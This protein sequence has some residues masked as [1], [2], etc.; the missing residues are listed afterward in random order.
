MA[1]QW[2]KWLPPTL[3]QLKK[4]S[5]KY[6]S[7]DPA[8]KGVK[9]FLFQISN[10][11]LLKS[12]PKCIVEQQLVCDKTPPTVEFT[13]KNDHKWLLPVSGRTDNEILM[14][15][16][17]QT[18]RLHLSTGLGEEDDMIDEEDEEAQMAARGKK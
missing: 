7:W 18:E 16:A 3:A 17:L 1:H 12:N 10:N 14:E 5:I 6:D 11:K 15:M 8:A 4:V 9:T 13:F 2:R